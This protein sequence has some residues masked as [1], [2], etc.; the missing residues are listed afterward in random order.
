MTSTVK[1]TFINIE[2]ETAT[3][4]KRGGRRT[5]TEPGAFA[6]CLMPEESDDD[7]E[8][9]S[10]QPTLEYAKTFDPFDIPALQAGAKGSPHQ[11][12]VMVTAAEED[13]VEQKTSVRNTFVELKE[14]TLE[15]RSL[16]RTKTA[17]PKKVGFLGCG[18]DEDAEDDDDD[19]DDV[20]VDSDGPRPG[21]VHHSTYDNFE[22][23]TPLANGTLQ[24][25]ACLGP[26]RQVSACPGTQRQISI[27]SQ[28][29]LTGSPQ[30]VNYR[31]SLQQPAL[32]Q[33]VVVQMNIPAGLPVGTSHSVNLPA[34]LP[35]GTTLILVP[36]AMGSVAGPTSAGTDQSAAAPKQATPSSPPSSKPSSKPTS[37]AGS[38][39]TQTIRKFEGKDGALRIKYVVDARKLKANDKAIISPPFEISA[40]NPG[41]YRVVINPS[42]IKARGGP[43]FKNSSGMG[44]VQLKCENP[45]EGGNISF[46]IAIN[47]GRPNTSKSEP[48]RGPI[49]HSFADGAVCGLRKTQEEWDFNR[50]VDH[51]TKTFSVFIDIAR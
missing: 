15:E 25:L 13:C 41:Q 48:A 39:K 36:T 50:V 2:E 6:N 20:E 11:R 29:G 35:P 40:A 42:P 4:S 51:S 14:P 34:G 31:Q 30:S 5:K 43:T 47:D 44:N 28:I 3:P 24:T 23:Q 9:E 46:M 8:E 26:Q 17:P 12:Q 27:S 38:P 49:E 22:A 16:R 37:P 19:S 10:V 32:Q 33:P 18:L 1:N 21:L 7:E 45:A